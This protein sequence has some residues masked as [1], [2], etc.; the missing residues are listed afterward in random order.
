MLVLGDDE[1]TAADCIIQCVVQ[2]S[3]PHVQPFP[4]NTKK[5]TSVIPWKQEM[6]VWEYQ[7][8]GKW[9]PGNRFPSCKTRIYFVHLETTISEKNAN[10]PNYKYV[11]NLDTNVMKTRKTAHTAMTQT[12]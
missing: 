9:V 5:L 11:W 7:V 8:P 3:Q 12:Y 6:T 4:F 10:L 2:I 1:C